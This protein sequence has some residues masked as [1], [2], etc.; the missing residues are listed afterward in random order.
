MYI[1]NQYTVSDAN[2]YLSQTFESIGKIVSLNNVPYLI[3]CIYQPPNSNIETF[4]HDVEAYLSQLSIQYF[5]VSH[6]IIRGDFNIDLFAKSNY[7]D[8]FIN[9]LMFYNMFPSIFQSIHPSSGTLIDNVFISRPGMI[10]SYI[11]SFDIS[12][13]VP[14]ITRVKQD[15]AI[16]TCSNVVVSRLFNETNLKAFR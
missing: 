16:I 8:S 13:H 11:L 5:I 14:T 1:S 3:L 7:A 4:L 2:P 9:I 12:D 10:D 15:N 6:W